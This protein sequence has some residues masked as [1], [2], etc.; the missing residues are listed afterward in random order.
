MF[1]CL[2]VGKQ[3]SKVWSQPVAASSDDARCLTLVST[4]AQVSFEFETVQTLTVYIAGISHILNSGG[5]IVQLEEGQQPVAAAASSSAPAAAPKGNGRRYSVMPFIAPAEL[6]TNPQEVVNQLAARRPTLMALSA[7]S[8]ILLMEEG[9][10]FTR[11]FTKPD[12]SVAKERVQLFVQQAGARGSVD[13]VYWCAPTAPGLPA[14]NLAQPNQRVVL[15]QVTDI[16]MGKQSKE[17][18]SPVAADAPH[19]NCLTIVSPSVSLNICAPNL[20]LLSAW[21]F[22]LNR[23]LAQQGRDIALDEVSKPATAKTVESRRY[24][25][26]HATKTSSASMPRL[27]SHALCLSPLCFFV[28]LDSLWW[29][30][31][32]QPL[33][34][35]PVSACLWPGL[36]SV[37]S[38]CRPM[39]TCWR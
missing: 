34:R 3:Y 35:P 7:A 23:L 12:G 6:P 21:L 4:N 13:A 18:K 10:M 22:G 14:V 24:E 33:R 8:T 2:S 11:Y 31:A 28:W 29:L 30:A 15:S 36:R 20:E 9:R 38:P 19:S 1:S 26:E 5:M 25:D 16:F 39:R 17:L 37:A 32:R 27:F